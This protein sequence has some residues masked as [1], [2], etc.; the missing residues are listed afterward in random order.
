MDPS[1][2][3]PHIGGCGWRE[4]GRR[5][6]PLILSTTQFNKL[7]SIDTVS[8]HRK[9]TYLFFL[10][11][12]LDSKSI[13]ESSESVPDFRLLAS[14]NPGSAGAPTIT[15]TGAF[16]ARCILQGTQYLREGSSQNLLQSS[17]PWLA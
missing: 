12:I 14:F 6:D 13:I 16:V 10:F 7:C 15:L 2:S 9:Q 5:V 4:S 8:G 3:F 1:S 17:H 11:G